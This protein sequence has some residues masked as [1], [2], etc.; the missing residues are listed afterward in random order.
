MQV[1][2]LN[3]AAAFQGLLEETLKM[4]KG[5]PEE[6]VASLAIS[7]VAGELRESRIES[8]EEGSSHQENLKAI[9]QNAL[10]RLQVSPQPTLACH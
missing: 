4:S 8:L 5:H 9:L 6:G 7:L 3:R 2:W 1:E 10:Q